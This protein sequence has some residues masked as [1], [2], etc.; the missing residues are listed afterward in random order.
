MALQPLIG[1]RKTLP[2][3]QRRR[4]R[5]FLPFRMEGRVLERRKFREE[6][7]H[8]QRELAI[9][10]GVRCPV[11]GRQHRGDR[12]GVDALAF[13][14][15]VRIIFRGQHRRQIV[16]LQRLGIVDRN[17]VEAVAIVL[18]GADR[19]VRLA[20]DGNHRVEF[21]FL[22]HLHRDALLDIDE[23]RLEA[24]PLEHDRCRDEGAAIGKVDADPL[25]VEIGET[26]DRFR[27]DDIHLF[28]VKLGHIGELLLDVLRKAFPLEVIKRIGAYDAEIDALQEQNVGD[29]LHRPAPDDR[30][31][32]QLVTVVEHG[33][34]VGADLHI[35]AADRTGDQRDGVLVQGLLGGGRTEL[36]NGLE[37][38]ADLG[39][40][41][42]G[43]FGSR[44]LAAN[45]G[46]GNQCHSKQ[47][48]HVSPCVVP[49]VK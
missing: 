36:E 8:E 5:D 45:H 46:D 17:E 12:D 40:I 34:E 1:D 20:A 9:A 47:T 42:F 4:Q 2:I 21:A 27:G 22:Q 16:A 14:N 3:L 38:F 24:E 25:A 41:E 28:V 7:V 11:V 44:R 49:A 18:E 19:L 32:A 30:Q 31:Y 39:R 33:G 13:R 29:A 6:R 37:A 35:G 43:L 48:S 26:V 23:V 15:Q 10:V